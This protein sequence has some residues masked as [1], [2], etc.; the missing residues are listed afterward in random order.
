MPGEISA[1]LSVT[2]LPTDLLDEVPMGVLVTD[3]A[4]TLVAVNRTAAEILGYTP[5]A[6]VGWNIVV[7]SPEAEPPPPGSG[8]PPTTAQRRRLRDKAGHQVVAE[9]RQRAQDGYVVYLLEAAPNAAQAARP[10]RESA[11]QLRVVAN[12]VPALL[13]YLDADA[14]YVW[15]NES[16]ERWFGAPPDSVRGQHASEVLGPAAWGAIRPHVDRVLAGEE[17][18]FEDRVR[19]KS[20]PARDIRA[21]YI[22]HRDAEGRV[23]GFVALVNDISEIRAAE[24]ALRRSEHL[25]EQSQSTAHVGS[26]EVTF[27]GGDYMNGELRWSTETYRIFGFAPGAVQPTQ[28]LF[29]GAIHPEDRD[30]TRSIARAGVRQGGP[31]EKEYR[32]VRPDGSVRILHSWTRLEHDSSGRPMR[33]LGT[34]QDVTERRRAEDALKEADQRKDE[35]LAMLAHELRNPLAPILNAAEVLES[36]GPDQHEI[37]AKFRTV[38]ARQV[39]HM[40]RLLD[41]LLDV[42]RV[43]QGKIQLRTERVELAALLAQAAEV[44]R[45]AIVEK[46]HQLSLTPPHGPLPLEADP[47]RLVQVFA[48]IVNNAA[49]YTDPGGHISVAAVGEGNEAV[50]TVRDDGMGMSPDLLARAFDLFVQETRSLDRAQGGLG[51]GLTMVRTLVRLHGGSVQAFSDGPGRGTAIVVRLPRAAAPEVTVPE[52]LPAPAPPKGHLRVLVVDDNIDAARALGRLLELLGHQVTLA[53]DGPEAIATADAVRPE[54]VLLDIGLPGMDGHA[55]ATRLRDAGHRRAALVA[56]TGHGQEDHR[57]RSTDAG[58]D[59]YLVKPVDFALL[60]QITAGVH[61][62]APSG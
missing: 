18:T 60:R 14:R 48:N 55:V 54:L 23:C 52:P 15:V 8:A 50:I 29:Y 33:M 32:I 40:K 38:I 31:F 10:R 57:R 5:E 47:T 37:T 62:G 53:H 46:R 39:Q 26:W 41:D 21:S 25:L 7:L 13:A 16:Y 12:A 2:T 9:R 17:I 51:I 36:A 49:K 43:S 30:S 61:R 11:E 19:Y 1:V 24:A 20:G 34:V 45:P 3:D 42:S 56:L 28:A 22:P 35:F 59:H 44:S 4:G 6:L 27:A 58:F